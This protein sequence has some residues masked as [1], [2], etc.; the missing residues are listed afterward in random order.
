M[1]SDTILIWFAGSKLAGVEAG[2]TR[3]RGA[4]VVSH[5]L[6][7]RHAPL[8][9]GFAEMTE[10]LPCKSDELPIESTQHFLDLRPIQDEAGRGD[11]VIARSAATKQSPA[12]EIQPNEIASLRSQ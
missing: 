5:D 10:C 9:P 7:A 2:R 12:G 1:C 3:E 11:S 4:K 6:G 8:Q